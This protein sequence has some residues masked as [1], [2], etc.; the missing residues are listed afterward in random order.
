MTDLRDQLDAAARRKEVTM[1]YRA[2]QLDKDEARHVPPITTLRDRA[3]AN[4]E[5]DP[6]IF[7]PPQ[8]GNANAARQ[9]CGRC[10]HQQACLD[11]ALKTRQNFG[12]WGGLT[13]DQREQVI[14]DRRAS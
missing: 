4:P 2:H 7:F 8:A 14:R 1:K 6:E 10:P 5:I 9:V 11:W 12:V 3:C 13:P